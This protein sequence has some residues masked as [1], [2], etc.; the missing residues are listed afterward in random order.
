[1]DRKRK[2]STDRMPT[3]LL[4]FSDAPSAKSGLA[5]ITRDIATRIA[6]KMSDQFFVATIGYGAPGSIELPFF[7]YSWNMRDD[8]HIPELPEIWNDF[9]RGEPGILLTIQDPSLVLWLSDPQFGQI[10]SLSKWVKQMRDTGMMRLWGYFPLDAVG[11]NGKLT[12][13]LAHTIAGYDRRLM[14]TKWAERIVKDSLSEFGEAE[15]ESIP[16]GIDTEVFTAYDR[17]ICKRDFGSLIE[18]AKPISIPL[19]ALAIGIVATN[20]RRKDWG[21]AAQVIAQIAKERE[22]FVWAHTDALKREWSILELF[23]DLGLLNRTAVTT[24]N[25]SN[26]RMSQLYSAMDITLGIGM[27]EGFGYPIFESIACGVPVIHCDYGGAAEFLPCWMKIKPDIMRVEGPFNFMRPVF[28]PASWVTAI[29]TA[30]RNPNETVLPPE[31][32]WD[33]LWPRFE[34]WFLDG[35]N[36]PI[37]TILTRSAIQ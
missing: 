30:L 20:Q 29:N 18:S 6:T 8:F 13:Q 5:R 35:I 11:V 16:H 26:E 27:S 4:I 14:Y 31:L 37:P 17:R 23:S 21:L 12:P 32:N 1:M 2:E 24:H 22:V 28:E 25:F 33:N 7:Q 15:V 3:P 19:E 10:P 34:K 9:T 36:E